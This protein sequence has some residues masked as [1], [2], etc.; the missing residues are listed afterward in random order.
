[1]K[2]IIARKFFAVLRYF[3]YTRFARVSKGPVKSAASDSQ[4]L[5][6]NWLRAALKAINSELEKQLI[7][8]GFEPD[9][10]RSGLFTLTC[11]ITEDPVDP[12]IKNQTY[13]V[14]TIEVMRVTWKINGFSILVRPRHDAKDIK[15]QIDKG[16]KSISDTTKPLITTGSTKEDIEIAIKAEQMVKE[17]DEMKAPDANDPE[18]IRK[19]SIQVDPLEAEKLLNQGGII[20]HLK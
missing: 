7:M 1:M 4:V 3:G 13:R 15:K 5:L 18:L 6:N 20:R 9:R 12:N 14:G 19:N 2:A 8:N 16:M 17:F 11:E 10:L